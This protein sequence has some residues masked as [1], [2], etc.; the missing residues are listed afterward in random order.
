M[1]VQILDLETEEEAEIETE[2]EVEIEKE[3]EI[4]I[5]LEEIV[6]EKEEDRNIF[7]ILTDL[8]NN[9]NKI[10]RMGYI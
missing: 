6:V 8:L 10:L 4:E 2:G 1:K 3:V 9:T 7:L 5:P